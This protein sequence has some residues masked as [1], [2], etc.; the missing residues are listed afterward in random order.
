MKDKQPISARDFPWQYFVC[1][2]VYPSPQWSHTE[3]VRGILN[4]KKKNNREEELYFQSHLLLNYPSQ[5]LLV[6]EWVEGYRISQFWKEKYYTSKKTHFKKVSSKVLYRC[7]LPSVSLFKCS[8]V[9]S[10]YYLLSYL[11]YIGKL[12]R[13]T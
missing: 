9:L 7:L 3:R 10:Y 11:L 6:S 13:Q 1:T 8:A 5:W 12:Q 4:W 2:G